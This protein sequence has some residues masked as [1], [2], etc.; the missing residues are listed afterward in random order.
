MKRGGQC[1][2]LLQQTVVP[3]NRY[4]G[5]DPLAPNVLISARNLPNM[6]GGRKSR[7]HRGGQWSPFLNDPILGLRSNLTSQTAF[8]TTT[9]AGWNAN[10]VMG[11]TNDAGPNFNFP[12]QPVFMV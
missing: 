9:G 8:G 2:N 7:K 10:A 6:T 5:P 3:L 1:S 12:R 11:K 4:T